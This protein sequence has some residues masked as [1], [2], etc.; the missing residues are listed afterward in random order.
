MA[1]SFSTCFVP[2]TLWRTGGT[3][4]RWQ[5][6]GGLG[7]ICQR[8][9]ISSNP[10]CHQHKG[11]ENGAQRITPQFPHTSW[12]LF[13][14]PQPSSVS[15]GIHKAIL[16]ALPTDFIASLP[17]PL[18]FLKRSEYIQKPSPLRRSH[19]SCSWSRHLGCGL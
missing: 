14:N 3:I 12:S 15:L 1:N 8:K 19:F 13:M 4:R 17:K 10:V 9:W 16:R 11:A 5:S 7:V 2:R 18:P 6:H